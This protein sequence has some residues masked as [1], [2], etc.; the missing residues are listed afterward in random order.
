MR[1]ALLCIATLLAFAA[2][3]AADITVDG[4]PVYVCLNN[5]CTPCPEPVTVPTPPDVSFTFTGSEC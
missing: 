3:A 1:L 5:I 2:P 4:P